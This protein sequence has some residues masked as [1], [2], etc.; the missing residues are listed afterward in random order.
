MPKEKEKT[1]EEVIEEKPKEETPK[2]DPEVTPEEQ[3][4]P[5]E[6]I[7]SLQ[8]EVKTLKEDKEKDKAEIESLRTKNEELSSSVV[9]I[10]DELKKFKE[11]YAEQFNSGST[12]VKPTN[13]DDPSPKFNSI[14]DLFMDA[15][16][17]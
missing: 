1:P 9:G 10:K 12:K 6:L 8:E 15:M 13:I 7:A 2:E 16:Q 3:P 11:A 5:E 4:K 17:R 14:E